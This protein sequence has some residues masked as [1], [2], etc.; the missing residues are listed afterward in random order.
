M[1]VDAG[2]RFDGISWA[3]GTTAPRI[4]SSF[5]TSSGRTVAGGG[6]GLFYDKIPLNIG[7]FGQYLSQLVTTFDVNG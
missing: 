6:V 2:L 1:T 4:D 3:A 7:A 5:P